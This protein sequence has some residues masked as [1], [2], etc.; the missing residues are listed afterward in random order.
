M[1]STITFFEHEP[2]EFPWTDHDLASLER[3]RRLVGCEVLRPTVRH[4]V[5]SLQA[6]QQVGVIRLGDRTV[7]VLPKM[8]KSSPVVDEKTRAREATHN[9]LHLLAYAGK[10]PISESIVAPLLRRD[11]DWFEIL[12]SLFARHLTEHWQLGAHRTY[13]AVDDELPVLKGKWRL[14]DQLRRPERKHIFAISYDEFTADNPLNRVF[15]FV[16]ERLWHLTRVGQNLR[17]LGELRQWM[18]DVTLLPSVTVSAASP[19]LIT[20]LN[21]DCAPL[22]SLAR[23]FLDQ[24][25]LQLAAGDL[26]TYAFV[27][28]MNRLFEAF[29]VAFIR[30]ESHRVLPPTLAGCELLPY[31][32]GA[33]RY[34]AKRAKRQVF[35]LEPDLAFRYGG[36]FRLLIDAKYKQLDETSRRLGVSEEDFYQM[37]A[38]AH[39]YRAP[40]VLLLYPQVAGVSSDLGGLF[41][42]ED[43]DKE[44]TVATVDLR[45]DLGRSEERQKLA[46]RLRAL[47]EKDDGHGVANQELAV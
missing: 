8:Y 15:R 38:Y 20:R 35:Q 36:Q 11:A 25:A 37:Y 23:L 6:T 17:M 2:L 12:T 32:S 45:N 5:R 18:D 4:G 14:T 21:Q 33:A 43:E 34:L 1:G 46:D 42:I 9:L 24:G 39:R 16:V 41:T 31:A 40:R 44:I 28:D 3:L 27:F 29:I 30:R 13:Q 10:L 22:L 7:Q 26:N 19:A 47:L